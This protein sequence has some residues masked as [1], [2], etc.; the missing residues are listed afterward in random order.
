MILGRREISVQIRFAENPGSVQAYADVQF[1]FSDGELLLVGFA[2]IQHPGKDVF[3]A[4]PQNRGRD[5]YFPVVAA[6]GD[7][8]DE[9]IKEILRAYK[10]AKE[11]QRSSQAGRG[12]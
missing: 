1:A 12:L 9:I 5:R 6:K 3:I 2:V 7:L 11:R 4:F 8:R 10:Q